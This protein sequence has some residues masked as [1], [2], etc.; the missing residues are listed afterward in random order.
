MFV[1]KANIFSAIN[2]RSRCNQEFGAP[3]NVNEPAG[4]T[5]AG[6]TARM[7]VPG[8]PREFT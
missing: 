7:T 4:G 8:S 3:V 6:P 1:E 5:P 2:P